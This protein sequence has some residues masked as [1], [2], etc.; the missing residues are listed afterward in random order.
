MAWL[1]LDDASVEDDGARVAAE[2]RRFLHLVRDEPDAAV[3]VIEMSGVA[4]ERLTPVQPLQD[5]LRSLPQ[6]TIAKLRGCL[7]ARGAALALSADLRF[8]S[9]RAEE[10]GWVHR[11]VPDDRLDA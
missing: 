5:Q 11:V 4:L 1:A 3:V 7:R 6:I 2:L 9:A 10:S 8:A